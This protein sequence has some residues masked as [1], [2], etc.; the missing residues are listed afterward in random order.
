[1]AWHLI[2]DVDEFAGSAGEFLAARPVEHTVLLTLIDTLRRRGP[3]A[4]GTADPIFGCWRSPA[5]PVDG[6]LLQTP[7]HPMLFT[8]LPPAA[9]PAAAAALTG[10]PLTGA[11]LLAGDVDA[12]VAAWGAPAKVDMRTRLYRLGT[13]TPPSPMP[14]GAARRA[15]PGDRDLVA[16]WMSAF[17]ADIGEGHS[18]PAALPDDVMLWEIGGVPVAIATRSRPAHG[19]VRIQ[20]VYTPPERRGHGFAGA[21]TAAAARTADAAEI[22]LYTDLANPTSNGLYRR[23]GFQPVED[24]TVVEFGS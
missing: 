4:Y 21:V 7:P 1:M 2:S 19:M 3:H 24:R 12:F 22:V 18:A 15:G 10:R 11:N 23:L 6:L 5:G 16:R 20:H 13:L 8:A 14:P 9:V 17:F